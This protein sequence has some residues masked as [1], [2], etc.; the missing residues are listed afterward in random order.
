MARGLVLGILVAIGGLSIS[1]AGFQNEPVGAA[2]QGRG[3]EGGARGLLPQGPPVVQ[4]QRVKDNLYMLTGGGG[5]SAVF[6]TDGGVV[7]VD[8]NF[9]DYGQAIMDKIKTV[10]DKPVTMIINTHNHGDHVGSN[11]FFGAAVE[12]VAQEN[13]RTLM[14]QADPF[15][16]EKAAFLPRTVYKDKMTIGRGKDQIELYYF[17]PSHT[18]NDTWVVFKTARVMHSG[19]VFAGNMSPIVDAPSG[20]SSVRFSKTLQRAGE[21]RDIDAII[22][23]HSPLMT[24]A[25]MKAYER[26]T[27]DFVTWVAAQ[28]KAGKT[29]DQAAADY[30]LPAANFANPFFGG[31][32]GWIQTTYNE[33]DA[34]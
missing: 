2:G 10:T 21:L 26:F 8:T 20:G 32:R 25:D 15:K 19:D 23:G 27:A 5:N 6:V 3:R 17:G 30:T 4:I 31:I 28:K 29:V 22:T 11:E 7:L 24:M 33:L 13:A 9:A 18:D 16:G 1:L 14:A 34:K 12:I